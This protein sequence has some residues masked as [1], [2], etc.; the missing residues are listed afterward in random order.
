M[1]FFTLLKP[2]LLLKICLKQFYRQLRQN[3]ARV[4]A[5]LFT[6]GLCISLGFTGCN[7]SNSDVHS[8]EAQPVVSNV[9]SAAKKVVN[10]GYQKSAV[11]ALVKH[12]GSLEKQLSPSGVAVKWL[13]FPSGPPMLEALN[14]NSI[15][16]ATVGEAPPVFAQSA[17]VPLVY[18]GNSS[19]SPEGLAILIRNNSPIRTVADLKGKKV[20]VTKG[21]SAHFMVTQALASVGLQYTDIQPVYLSPADAR[22]AFEQGN[23]DAWGIWDPFLAAAQ[24]HGGARILRDGKGIASWREFFVTSKN[25]ANANPEIVKQILT[26]INEVGSWAKKNPHQVVEILAPQLG[27]DVPSL[28]LAESRRKRYDVQPISSSIIAEQ[29]KVADTFLRLKMLP[30]PIKVAEAV[31]QPK[32]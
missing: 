17:G 14:A 9:A 20:G 8:S 28:D 31:W 6:L 24:R 3:S 29:Q 4:F 11:L 16:F 27:I 1:N 22:A 2:L 21:S 19:A 25:F 26:T 15:D 30:K 10:I 7:S 13:E 18:V 12:K 23:I 32:S 5:L